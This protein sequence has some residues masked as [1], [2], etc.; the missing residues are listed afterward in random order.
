M[1]KLR[2]GYDVKYVSVQGL[3]E[4]SLTT[5]ALQF[6]QDVGDPRQHPSWP[7]FVEYASRVR[8]IRLFPFDGPAWCGLWEELLFRT[9]GRSI[10]PSL[11]TV[12][13]YGVYSRRSLCLGAPTLI[14]PSVRKPDFS[15]MDESVWRSLA[16]GRRR[17]LLTPAASCASRLTSRFTSGGLHRTM[18][19]PLQR[20]PVAR[21]RGAARQRRYR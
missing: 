8:T 20:P 7:R 11:A 18:C 14:P 17:T 9:G 13:L 3:R 21:R 2:R 12:A 16:P 1:W 5:P 15:I 6:L 4:Q 10:L 19:L